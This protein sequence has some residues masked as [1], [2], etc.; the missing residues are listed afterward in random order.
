MAR[1]N[2]S[3]S[4][5]FATALS[6]TVRKLCGAFILVSLFQKAKL[7]SEWRASTVGQL[8]HQ[9]IISYKKVDSGQ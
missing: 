4:G 3:V 2:S 9:C 6:E 1:A 8:V 5:G 7:Q